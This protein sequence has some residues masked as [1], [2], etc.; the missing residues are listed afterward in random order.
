MSESEIS[1]KHLGASFIICAILGIVISELMDLAGDEVDEIEARDA[2][3][4]SAMNAT[5]IDA[6]G[7]YISRERPDARHWQIICGINGSI[8]KY[9]TYDDGKTAWRE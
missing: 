2:E 1:W 8:V 4:L 5:C 9:V 7:R 6:G 3:M